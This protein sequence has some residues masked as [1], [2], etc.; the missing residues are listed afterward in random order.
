[1]QTLDQSLMQQE[2]RDTPRRMRDQQSALQSLLP[3]LVA[4]LKSKPP[5]LLITCGRGSSD[6]AGV[7]IR[8]LFEAALGIPSSS[9]TPSTL[10]VYGKHTRLDDC[11]VL[12]ISQ[13]GQSPDLVEYAQAAKASGALTV[14]LI[15]QEGS[16][17][18]GEHCDFV[19]PLHAGA[20]LSVAATKSWLA[21]LYA[22][23]QLLA[24]WTESPQLHQD[25]NTLPDHLQAAQSHDWHAATDLLQNSSNMLVL[26]RGPGLGVANEIALKFKETC[27]LH[28]E[29][30]SAA[31]VLHGPLAMVGPEL[32]VLIFDQ[33]DDGSDSIRET[34]DRLRQTGAPLLLAS[35]ETQAGCTALPST[36]NLSP[37]CTLMT[38]AQSSYLM[39]EQ[40][41]K[42]RGFNPDMPAHIAKVTKTL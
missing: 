10:S 11:L 40:L 17:P 2:T 29:S 19:L 30:F 32:P 42:L 33:G 38:Q 25:I 14:G 7:F 27:G 8:Y 5:R 15:N 22:A 31:E 1:M 21:T 39:I 37:W 16:T 36:P 12:L 28:A 26:G 3:T 20:E 18:L 35:A 9:A 34:I 13:S 6:H 4:Q 41:S 24:H 23:M